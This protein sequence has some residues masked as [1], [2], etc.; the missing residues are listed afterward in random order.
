MSVPPGDD[1]RAPARTR[2]RIF[3][4]RPR[5]GRRR[6]GRAFQSLLAAAALAALGVT[7]APAARP[8]PPPGPPDPRSRGWT[9]TSWP[10]STAPGDSPGWPGSAP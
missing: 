2:F 1:G 9:G 10:W 8:Q 6:T 3:T 4:R 5:S 7:A